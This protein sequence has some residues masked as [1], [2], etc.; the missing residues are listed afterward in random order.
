MTVGMITLHN[1]CKNYTNGIVNIAVLKGIS[2]SIEHG[3]F[4]S[5]MGASGSGKT[6]LL[7]I[8]GLLDDAT[9]G[10]YL[11]QGTDVISVPENLQAEIRN[12]QFGFVFQSFHLLPRLTAL[13]N[14][15]L[16]LFYQSV[17]KQE[18]RHLAFMQLERVGLA[19]RAQHR[20]EELS[21]G[22]RQRVAIA[23]ALIG[24][25]SLILADE[26]TGNLDSVAAQDI[27][28]LLT[29]LNRETGVA[30]IM[31]THD[32]SMSRQCSRRIFIQDGVLV[33]DEKG[34][35]DSVKGS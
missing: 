24:Q 16:P 27:L 8:L 1:I 22:Q 23:R 11:Y 2:L 7:N 35:T 15:A 26:P 29:T 32:A 18:S 4:C 20:P 21:G 17:S 19:D 6:T 34:R 9:S 10:Q 12:R 33:K 3:E 25:P 28:H 31:V 13:D 30:I 5:I 14:V